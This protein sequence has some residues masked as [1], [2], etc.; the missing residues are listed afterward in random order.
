MLNRDTDEASACRATCFWN[1]L[2]LIPLMFYFLGGFIGGGSSMLSI[3][4]PLV[5]LGGFIGCTCLSIAKSRAF[6]DPGSYPKDPGAAAAAARGS[7]TQQMT[8]LQ[9]QGSQMLNRLS[10]PGPST[11][12]AGLQR[13]NSGSSG[14]FGPGSNPV[15]LRASDSGPYGNPYG[16]PPTSVPFATG[17][18]ASAPSGNRWQVEMEPGKWV[19]FDENERRCCFQKERGHI[20]N[21]RS[22]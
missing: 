17:M 22:E 19:D 9:Q 11:V 2:L 12:G 6:S 8:Q 20:E 1:S 5:L 13:S 7:F 16:G 15:R 21:G 18:A 10:D 4:V 14:S 3:L